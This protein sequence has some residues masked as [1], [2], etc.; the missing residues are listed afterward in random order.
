MQTHQTLLTACQHLI[1]CPLAAHLLSDSLSTSTLSDDTL[2]SSLDSGPN[3]EIEKDSLDEVLEEQQ[4]AWEDATGEVQTDLL[5]PNYPIDHQ[6][7]CGINS[8]A[9][10][11]VNKAE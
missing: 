8:I 11:L 4:I 7:I 9:S 1:S 10:R 2:N 6:M 5:E 3:E